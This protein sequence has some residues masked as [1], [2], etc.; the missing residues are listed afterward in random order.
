MDYA[1]FNFFDLSFLLRFGKTKFE[2][3]EKDMKKFAVIMAGGKG[4]KLWPRSTENMPK[5]FIHLMGDGTMIQ[6]TFN[7]IKKYIDIEDIYVVTYAD[8]KKEVHS[9]LPELPPENMIIE[10][11]G[12]NTAPCLGLAATVL[13]EKYNDDDIMIAFPSDHVIMNKGDLYQSLDTA[14]RAAY[15]LN[16]LVTIGVKPTMPETQY[17]YVQVT[18]EELGLGELY[19]RGLRKSTAFAEKPDIETAKRFIESGDFLWNTGIF[20]WKLSVFVRSFNK[21]L[22]EH[23]D[24]FTDLKMQ[25]GKDFFHKK[26]ELTYGKMDSISIDYGVLEKADNVYLVKADLNWS[27]LGT[28]DEVYNQSRKDAK[29]NV[30]LGDVLAVNTKN[31]FI[32]SRGKL[33]GVIGMEDVIIVNSDEAMFVCKRGQSEEIQQIIE[34]LRSRHLNNFL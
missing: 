31:S 3:M 11:F 32:S 7:R 33:I 21:Y 17:G 12:I 4:T 19:K 8:L 9:Q 20:V 2:S 27:D 29:N 15:D 5:Q 14:T 30:F 26:L 10:P 1:K 13:S 34:L 22:P 25:F 18:E 16:G 24:Y 28:W 6:N 23:G